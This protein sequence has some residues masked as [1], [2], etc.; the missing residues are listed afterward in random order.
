MVS[1]VGRRADLRRVPVKKREADTHDYGCGSGK[2]MY[3]YVHVVSEKYNVRSVSRVYNEVIRVLGVIENMHWEKTVFLF[4]TW[5][6]NY[7]Q[8]YVNRLLH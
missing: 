3:I 6:C 7:K 4:L 1:A 8:R 5:G 2:R